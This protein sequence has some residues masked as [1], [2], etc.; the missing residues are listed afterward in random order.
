DL[1]QVSARTNLDET[2]FFFPHLLSDAEGVV[3][4]EFTIPEALTEWRFLGFAHD[5]QLRSGFLTGTTVTAKDL[6]V[7]PNPPRFVREG[8]IIEFTVKVTNQSAARQTGK[9]SLTLA[10]ARTLESR[11]EALG[12]LSPEQTFDVPSQ[13]SRTYSWRLT[14]PDE[15]DFLTYRAVGATSRL[16]DGEE[17]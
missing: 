1:D 16:S 9:V 6:M 2:A 11:D 17:A 14:V 5:N 13:E 7:E 10:D 15:C 4:I 12:N 8:D 3:R